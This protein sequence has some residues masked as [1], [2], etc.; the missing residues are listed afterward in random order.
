MSNLV[1]DRSYVID[2]DLEPPFILRIPSEPDA[3]LLPDIGFEEK[4]WQLCQIEIIANTETISTGQSDSSDSGF[5]IASAGL[6]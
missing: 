6:C 2:R 1:S 3:G 4:R 5:A